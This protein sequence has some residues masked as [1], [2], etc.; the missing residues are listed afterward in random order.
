VHVHINQWQ[1]DWLRL[2]IGQLIKK[3]NCVSLVLFSYV[4][5][6]APFCYYA[7]L[8][9]QH[10]KVVLVFGQPVQLW[11]LCTPCVSCNFMFRHSLFSCWMHWLN[12]SAQFPVVASKSLL[13][14][15]LCHS[16]FSIRVFTHEAATAFSALSCHNSVGLSVRPSHGWISQKRC[17]L[18]SPNLHRRLF[19][20]LWFQDP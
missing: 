4:A 5:L 7:S 20:R 10:L 17:K 6:Y 19:G 1:V 14:F 16:L 3:L 15:I 11:K 8:S 12:L 13:Y 2:P 9:C 18:R